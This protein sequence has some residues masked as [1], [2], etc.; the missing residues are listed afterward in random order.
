[1]VFETLLAHFRGDAR[2]V[3]SRARLRFSQIR[4]NTT[5]IAGFVECDI[6][7]DL[8]RLP[9]SQRRCHDCCLQG[10]KTKKT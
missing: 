2:F 6:V 8:D 7:L 9:L 3:E 5:V 1:M 4:Y 10:A